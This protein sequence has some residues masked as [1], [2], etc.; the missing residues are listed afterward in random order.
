MSKINVLSQMTIDNPHPTPQIFFSTEK[1]FSCVSFFER[2]Y[3]C[4]KT[5]SYYKNDFCLRIGE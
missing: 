1:T 3:N 5:V 4:I 2:K